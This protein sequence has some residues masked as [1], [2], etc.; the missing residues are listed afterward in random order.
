M[1]ESTAQALTELVPWEVRDQTESGDPGM[2]SMILLSMVNSPS[3]LPAYWSRNRDS[4]LANF[5]LESDAIKIAVNTFISKAV[6]VPLLILPNNR[7]IQSHVDLAEDM[8]EALE[9]NSGF[10]R[11]F[12]EEYKRF[13]YDWLT[14]DNGAFMLVLG[15]GK[16]TGPIVGR[17]SGVVHLPSSRC[18]RTSDPVYPVVYIHHDSRRFKIHYTRVITMVNLPSPDPDLRGV[19]K[20]PV[21][22]CIDAARELLDVTIYMQEKLGSRPAKQIL[23]AKTGATPQQIQAAMVDADMVMRNERLTRFSKTII[24]GPKQSSGKLELDILDLSSVPDGFDRQTSTLLAMATIA[25]AFGLDLRDLA[26]SFG[27]SGQTRS[28]AQIQHLKGLGKGVAQVADEFAKN[29]TR[30]YLPKS[31]TAMFDYVDDSQDEASAKI[32]A[33]RSTSRTRDIMGATLNTRVAREHML[34][35]GELTD[36]QFEELE[37]GDGRLPDGTSLMSLFFDSDEIY[38]TLLSLGVEDPTDVE[39]N[40]PGKMDK[41]IHRQL[42]QVW[43]ILN[44]TSAERDRKKLRYSAAA[45]ENLKKQYIEKKKSD[46][47][48]AQQEQVVAQGGKTAGIRTKPQ[49]VSELG[50]NRDQEKK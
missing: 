29:I 34:R 47:M 35:Y 21:T 49:K 48:A 8:G 38:S 13:L 20:C 26:Y 2:S 23:Y 17:A 43:I 15:R 11:G 42:K 14:Q 19:G 16:L 9:S 7:S 25:A 10:G 12:T 50:Q 1:A 40:D 28:D 18:M 24:L 46:E 6:N 22:L 31:L 30:Y 5:V 33:Q 37:L 32:I 41:A 27:I 45:L 3:F 4:R 44:G 36:Q 39:A